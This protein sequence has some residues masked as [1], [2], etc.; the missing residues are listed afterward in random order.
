MDYVIISVQWRGKVGASGL[1]LRA[2][3]GHTTASMTD[4]YSHLDAQAT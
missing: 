3:L 1:Q 4:H 2:Q